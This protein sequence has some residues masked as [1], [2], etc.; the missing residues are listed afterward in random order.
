M[1][2]LPWNCLSLIFRVCV[3]SLFRKLYTSFIMTCFCLLLRE[4]SA[5]SFCRLKFHRVCIRCASS[6]AAEHGDSVPVHHRQ[7][8]IMLRDIAKF[9]ETLPE[10]ERNAFQRFGSKLGRRVTTPQSL[11]CVD[12]K[13]ADVIAEYVA[14]DDPG[15]AGGVNP[16]VEIRP[17]PG[18]LSRAILDKGVPAL[19]M[20]EDSAQYSAFL[21]VRDLMELPLLKNIS[22]CRVYWLS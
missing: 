11:Y 4:M 12:K 22:V 14:G 15:N 5:L 16:I 20:Y 8:S 1:I 18:I 7:K 6:L 3:H 10:L 2:S 21:R 9:S 19:R 17:G 13:L